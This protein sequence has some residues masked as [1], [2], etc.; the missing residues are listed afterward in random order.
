MTPEEVKSLRREILIT[1]GRFLK[2]KDCRIIDS[3]PLSNFLNNI[4]IQCNT[5]EDILNTII[6]C[7]QR[8][9]TVLRS[10]KIICPL[11]LQFAFGKRSY[12]SR[13][14]ILDFILPQIEL[15]I[16]TRC[17]AVTRIDTAQITSNQRFK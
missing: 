15:V 16:T 4:H 11:S 2:D 1:L 5:I 14:D 6:T 17:T 7:L 12:I 9:G 8:D 10:G 3:T 13:I